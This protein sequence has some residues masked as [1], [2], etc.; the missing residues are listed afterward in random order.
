VLCVVCQRRQILEQQSR[1]GRVKSVTGSLQ[2]QTTAA[3][4]FDNLIT[5]V[6]VLCERE[7][8]ER[9]AAAKARL[10]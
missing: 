2:Q 1:G 10:R 6:G 7:Q 8:A 3:Y 4:C 5:L 9:E